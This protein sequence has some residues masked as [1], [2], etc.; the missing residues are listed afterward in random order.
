MTTSRRKL[1]I[2]AAVVCVL[3][4]VLALPQFATAGQLSFAGGVL[5][6]IIF[7]TS[8]NLLFGQAGIPSFGQAGFFGAGAYATA[9]AADRGA[10]VLISLVAGTVVAALVGLV[11]SLVAWRTT[12]LAFS[13]LTLAFAQSLYT[14]SIRSEFLGGY[15]GLSGFEMETI[16]GIDMSDPGFVWY[17]AAVVC[18]VVVAVFWVISHS[19]LGHILKALR[20]DPVRTLFLGINVRAY[21]AFAFVLAAAGAGAAGGLSAYLNQVVT[22][23]AL[24]WTES[25]T[26]IMM[27]LLGGMT[28]FFGPA[29]G[30]VAISGLQYWLSAWATSYIFYVGA[31]LYLILVFLPRGILSLPAIAGR[32]GRRGRHDTGIREVL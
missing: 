5:V 23:D 8:T 22:P 2:L 9:L 4:L 20:D 10:P 31:L 7:A 19:P 11:A 3:V 14:L 16:L 25:A 6:A 24:Y 29:V 18:A 12:G 1:S 17:F 28:F 27:I 21:R 15:N 26:P 32:F 13:M 30:A